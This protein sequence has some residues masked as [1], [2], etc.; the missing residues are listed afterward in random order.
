MKW[1]KSCANN[2]TAFLL[3]ILGVGVIYS[4]F[5]LDYKAWNPLGGP[6]E[7]PYIVQEGG[8]VLT[9]HL[10]DLALKP[11]TVFRQAESAFVQFHYTKKRHCEALVEIWRVQPN[12]ERRRVSQNRGETSGDELGPQSWLYAFNVGLDIGAHVLEFRVHQSCR[13][14]LHPDVL[15]YRFSFEVTR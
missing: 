10:T 4:A 13:F 6:P 12:G 5:G 9:S 3:V 1:C 15:V 8:T 2:A 7:V 14:S 11:T